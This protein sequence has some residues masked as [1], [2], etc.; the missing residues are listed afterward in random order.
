MYIKIV[1]Y[2]G[3]N[4]INFEN[5]LTFLI[6][7][8]STLPASQDKNLNILRT[9]RAFKMKQKAFLITFNGLLDLITC[10]RYLQKQAL[11]DVL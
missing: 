3:Y 2:P 11:T 7:R 8:F 10:G 5:Y 6:K 9:K 4:N 1:Y